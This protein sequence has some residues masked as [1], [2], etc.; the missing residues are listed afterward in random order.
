M[1]RFLILYLASAAMAFSQEYSGSVSNVPVR[2]DLGG[3]YGGQSF[4]NI[5]VTVATHMDLTPSTIFYRSYFV[6]SSEPQVL[7]LS[8][9]FPVPGTFEFRT[10]TA[11]LTLEPFVQALANFGPASL[12][13]GFGTTYYIMDQQGFTAARFQGHY[14]IS[15]PNETVS[16]AFNLSLLP[17]STHHS[18]P[19]VEVNV[20]GYPGSVLLLGTPNFTV[21][22]PLF[23]GTV[24]GIP[25]NIVAGGFG[26]MQQTNSS[27]TPGPPAQ[28]SVV[29]VVSRKIHGAAGVFD[30]NL[31]LIGQPG[32]E[33]RNSGGDHTLVFTL[34]NT[35]VGGSAMVA[36]GL[37]SVAGNPTFSGHDVVVE[38]TGVAD[39]QTI[40][41]TLHGLT[42]NFAQVLPDTTVTMKV[43]VGDAN[44]SGAVNA[45]D[46]SRI[47][48]QVGL[49]VT[50]AN[51]LTDLNVSGTV[52]ASDVA[53]AKINSGHALP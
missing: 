16:G 26:F 10:I 44:L 3:S 17:G 42:D 20:A 29:A 14:Q 38:L 22:S 47:K 25:L 41:V 31:P 48:T 28:P 33:C 34:N 13:Y 36:S 23:Q 43:L 30:I 35:M 21:S 52:T 46:V 53:Q 32:I 6:T 49:P 45:S 51:F 2:L 11:R 27:V 12:Q 1:K 40:A 18:M 9:Q 7:L 8:Q 15:G 37:G 5:P 39:L 24:D 50:S 4:L 19:N